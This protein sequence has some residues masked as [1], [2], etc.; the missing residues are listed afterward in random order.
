M[1]LVFNAAITSRVCFNVL[2]MPF[3]VWMIYI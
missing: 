2:L 3:G 1:H